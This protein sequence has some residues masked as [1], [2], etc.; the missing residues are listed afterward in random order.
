M[1]KVDDLRSPMLILRYYLKLFQLSWTLLIT[2]V[3][4]TNSSDYLIT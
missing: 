3:G 2:A 4:I 1:K